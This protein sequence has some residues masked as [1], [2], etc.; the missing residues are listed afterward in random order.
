MSLWLTNY[1]FFFKVVYDATYKLSWIFKVAAFWTYTVFV[2]ELEPYSQPHT[3]GSCQMSIFEIETNHDYLSH[4]VTLNSCI[5]LHLAFRSVSRH[6]QTPF[7]LDYSSLAWIF[8]LEGHQSVWL[9]MQESVCWSMF[10]ASHSF[11]HR[12]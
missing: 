7:Q 10:V 3:E 9:A 12:I 5:Q 4:I 11:A 8:N 2:H 1:C 6:V